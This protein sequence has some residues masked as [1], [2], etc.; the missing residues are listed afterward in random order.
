MGH[1]EIVNRL[2]AAGA[3]IDSRDT[4]ERTPLMYAVGGAHYEA[5]RVLLENRADPRA[6]AASGFCVLCAAV[7]ARGY[8]PEPDGTFAVRPFPEESIL[9]VVELLLRWGADDAPDSTGV[10]PSQ[11]AEGLS[12]FAVVR[13]LYDYAGE[14]YRKTG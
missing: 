12:H 1:A 6:E 7:C 2:L 10:R 8:F 3:R 4:E 13:V 11:H 9:P 14:E 5:A